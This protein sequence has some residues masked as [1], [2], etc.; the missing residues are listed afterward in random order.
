M[1]SCPQAP[2]RPADHAL[3]D[4]LFCF[5]NILGIINNPVTVL[6]PPRTIGISGPDGFR[7]LILQWEFRC[8]AL[9]SRISRPRW[10]PSSALD[11]PHSTNQIY[12]FTT[13]NNCYYD[14]V[15]LFLFN[16]QFSSRRSHSTRIEGLPAT[17]LNRSLRLIRKNSKYLVKAL[18]G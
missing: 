9:E 2:Q 16:L 13:L 10:L 1:P 8:T 11:R 4:K 5:S 3:K 12:L 6:H 7:A 17:G 18:F 14:P 15:E